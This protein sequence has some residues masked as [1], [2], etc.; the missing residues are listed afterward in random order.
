MQRF[1]IDTL[2]SWNTSEDFV[3]IGKAAVEKSLLYK[4]INKCFSKQH[5]PPY[6]HPRGYPPKMGEDLSEVRPNH[7]AKFHADW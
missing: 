3:P 7:R 6:G 4:K 5:M 1:V 2:A